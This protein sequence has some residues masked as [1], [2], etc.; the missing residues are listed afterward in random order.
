MFSVNNIFNHYTTTMR[1]IENS[2]FDQMY[3]QSFEF[4]LKG[5]ISPVSNNWTENWILY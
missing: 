4:P 2:D 5:T 1:Q 3:T